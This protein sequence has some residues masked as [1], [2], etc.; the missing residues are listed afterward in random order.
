MTTIERN[1]MAVARVVHAVRVMTGKTALEL[2]AF[3]VSVVGLTTMV[4]LSHVVQ[5]IGVVAGHGLVGV[6]AYL[7]VAVVKT[8]ILV[9]VALL[10]GTFS[11]VLFMRD[12]TR[13][14]RPTMRLA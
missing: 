2:Y 11:L 10:L 4:S 13:S 12:M 8:N 6:A 1:V 9:Q 3:V 7:G 14:L 5:N